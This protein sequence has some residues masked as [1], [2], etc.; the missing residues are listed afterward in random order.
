MA[1]PAAAGLES[2]FGRRGNGPPRASGRAAAGVVEGRALGF[3]AMHVQ[4]S[5]TVRFLGR[6]FA[7]AGCDGLGLFEPCQHGL[8]PVTTSGRLCRG[9]RCAYVVAAEGLV[10]DGL[11]IG[12]RGRDAEDARRGRG[13]ALFGRVPLPVEEAIDP[14]D[15]ECDGPFYRYEGLHAPVPFTGRWLIGWGA[16]PGPAELPDICRFRNV[17]DLVFENGRLVQAVDHSDRVARARARTRPVR[18]AAPADLFDMLGWIEHA[19]GLAA[20]AR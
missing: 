7:V 19:A 3:T 12:L 20:T 8:R 16:V 11:A 2:T 10:L 13:P 15:D 17:L 5:D 1:P 6:E 14:E 4:F 18:M 9:Y